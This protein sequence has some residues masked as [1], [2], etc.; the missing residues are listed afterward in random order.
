MSRL[1]SRVSALKGHQRRIHFVTF[2]HDQAPIAIA[3]MDAFVKLWDTPNTTAATVTEMG[4][5]QLSQQK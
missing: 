4:N 1:A 2:S 3:G 5:P